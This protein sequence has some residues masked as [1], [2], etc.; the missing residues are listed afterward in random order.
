MATDELRLQRNETHGNRKKSLVLVL[1]KFF[2]KKKG[3]EDGEAVLGFL[4]C[5]HQENQNATTT[6]SISFVP[7]QFHSQEGPHL[8]PPLVFLSAF[9][10]KM[11]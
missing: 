5:C 11:N 1:Q 2:P 3:M 9:S 4:R 7:L 8:L 10:L 6:A